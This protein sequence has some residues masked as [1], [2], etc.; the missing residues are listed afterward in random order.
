LGRQVAKYLTYCLAYAPFKKDKN[1]IICSSLQFGGRFL[2]ELNI[3][4]I[5]PYARLCVGFRSELKNYKYNHKNYLKNYI[6]INS[7][8]NIEKSNLRLLFNAKSVYYFVFN[9]Y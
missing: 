5:Q 6:L 7:K 8:I 3:T 9:S 4:T 2:G 1:H